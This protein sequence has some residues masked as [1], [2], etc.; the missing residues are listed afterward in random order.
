[1][2][3]ALDD[4]GRF[5][6][7]PSGPL[8]PFIL[9]DDVRDFGQDAVELFAGDPRIR[10]C[11]IEYPR[12]GGL[13]ERLASWERTV[14]ALQRET[15]GLSRSEYIVVDPDSRLGAPVFNRTVTLKDTWARI[16]GRDADTRRET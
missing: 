6:R 11:P 3:P 15:N 14:E 12:G 10:L 9:Q 7:V 4:P 2:P 8:V 16:A 5:G 1:M 13:V